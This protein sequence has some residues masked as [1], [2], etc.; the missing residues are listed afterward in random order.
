MDRATVDDRTVLEIKGLSASYDRSKVLENLDLTVASGSVVAIVGRSGCG[1]ST[2]LR[3]VCGLQHFDTGEVWFEGQ[4]I[5]ADGNV[6]YAEWE[7]CRH[8]MMVPQTPSLLPHLTARR[9]IEVGLIVVRGLN[10]QRARVEVEKVAELLGLASVLDQYPEQLSGGQAQRTQLA[11]ALVLRPTVLLL[12][13]VTSSIDPQ[14]T[15]EVVSALWRLRE[16]EQLNDRSQTMII[17]THALSFAFHYA[18]RIAFLHEG[19]ILEEHKAQDF[20]HKCQLE[21]TQYFLRAE[22]ELPVANDGQ[23]KLFSDSCPQKD[24]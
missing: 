18:D 7:I 2:L 23:N 16:M 10:K 20:A 19:R 21:E 5:I 6:E 11:R 14:T 8:I 24:G 15:R 17:V 4:R 13:E 22:M 1:K 3:C 9:N 12:D